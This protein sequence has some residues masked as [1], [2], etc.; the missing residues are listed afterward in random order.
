MTTGKKAVSNTRAYEKKTKG[1]AQKEKARKEVNNAVRDGKMKKPKG[2]CPNCG[3]TGGRMEF[4]HTK[5]YKTDGTPNGKW[6]CSKCHRR[7][8]G[9]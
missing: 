9:A 2:K 6:K 7:G 8:P 5:G 3:K 4:D 1:S